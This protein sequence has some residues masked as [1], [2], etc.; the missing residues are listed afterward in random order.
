MRKVVQTRLVRFRHLSPRAIRNG[1]AVLAMI[2]CVDVISA[3]FSAQIQATLTLPAQVADATN[4][5]SIRLPVMS[6]GA[7][8]ATARGVLAQDTFQRANQPLW[9]TASDGQAWG[10]DAARSSVFAVINRAGQVSSGSGIYDAILGPRASDSEV[11]FSGSVSHFSASNM[12]VL[13]RWTDANNLYK[14]FIDGAS[15]IALKKVAGVVTV[16]QSVPFAAQDGVPYSM[17]VRLVGT[18]ISARVWQS[19]QVE[20]ATWMLLANDTALTAGY[21]G[22]RVIVQTGITITI[23]S[24]LETKA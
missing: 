18:A 24:Y 22:L 23:T 8:T 1:V 21:D 14:V 3:G 16:L 9:G 7:A 13:L 10:A 20:P 15:L 12:G 2:F 11:L 6:N 17:R 19:G 4:G 5:S